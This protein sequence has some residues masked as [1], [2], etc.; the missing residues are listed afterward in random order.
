ME[1]LVHVLPLAIALAFS[2]V[3]I[4]AA[5]FI[6]LSPN[7]SRSSLPFL[8]GWI[9]GMFGVVAVCTMAAQVVPASRLPRRQ[10]ETVGV[11]EMI[12]GVA[13]IVLGLFSLWRARRRQEH[14]V[15]GWLKSVETVGP[16]SSFG[17][18][19]LLNVRPK[20]L[21][22]AFAAGLA[23]RADAHSV[24]ETVVIL[25]VYTAI[26]AS[27]VAVPII[28]TMASP[29]RMEP[30]LIETREWLTRNGEVITSIILLAVGAIVIFVGISRL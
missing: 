12:L 26:G 28:A 10:D 3:P 20:S 30:R 16:W 24:P 25:A 4:L 7:R 14:A 8:I 19:I 1:A 18:A 17:L 13:M 5:L 6:L 15:P 2:T 22:L 23:L 9:G 11:L 29:K 21:L 27:T